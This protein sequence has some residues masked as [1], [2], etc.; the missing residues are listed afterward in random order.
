M[1]DCEIMGPRLATVG[2]AV[3]LDVVVRGVPA[4]HR[5][6]IR[7]DRLW[8]EPSAHVEARNTRGLGGSTVTSSFLWRARTIG[9]R[10]PHGTVVLRATVRCRGTSCARTHGIEV[11]RADVRDPALAVERDPIPRRN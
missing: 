2:E 3:R 5:L 6:R 4:R 1:I 11:F 8:P 7:L 10:Q 9:A